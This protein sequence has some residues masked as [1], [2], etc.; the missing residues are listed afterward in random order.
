MLTTRSPASLVVGGEG[1]IRDEYRIA[2]G[3]QPDIVIA[4]GTWLSLVERCTGGAEVASSN[5]VVPTVV[6]YCCYS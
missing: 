4:Y 6:G 3:I 5:L 2:T 1:A